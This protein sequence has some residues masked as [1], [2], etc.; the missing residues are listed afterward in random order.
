M[1]TSDNPVYKESESI[2]PTVY[3]TSYKKNRFYC[4]S[5]R[6]PE[7][8]STSGTV[9]DIL[10]EKPTREESIAVPILRDGPGNNAT[11]HTTFGD[12]HMRLFPEFA[13]KA[14][15]NFVGLARKKYFDGIVFHRI[16]KGFMIQ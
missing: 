15:E 7:D 16:I 3:C 10:N 2:D 12:I 4:F 1:A 5:K 11:I 13:P 8:S 6:E 14:V 9:R